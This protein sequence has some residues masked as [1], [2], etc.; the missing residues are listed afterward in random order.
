MPV[1]WVIVDVSLSHTKQVGEPEWLSRYSDQLWAG[2]SG[3]RILAGA[4]DFISS[5]T[6]QTDSGDHS[7]WQSVGGGVTSRERSGQ[8]VMLTTHPHIVPKIRMTA[9]ITLLPLHAFVE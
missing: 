1:E 8:G 5:K 9:G 4:R 6:V 7:A 3:V 2:R